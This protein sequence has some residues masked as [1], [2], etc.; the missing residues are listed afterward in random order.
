MAIPDEVNQAVDEARTLAQENVNLVWCYPTQLDK[1]LA[2][3]KP[4]V[5][6]LREKGCAVEVHP[7]DRASN[8]VAR[9]NSMLIE[10]EA[11]PTQARIVEKSEG[12]KL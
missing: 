1:V 11:G 5:Q 6:Y 12:W 9:I 3:L 8:V 10:A 7:H 2:K 4:A